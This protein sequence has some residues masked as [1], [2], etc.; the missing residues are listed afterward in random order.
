MGTGTITRAELKDQ[1][2]AVHL[3]GRGSRQFFKLFN[4]FSISG[5]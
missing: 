5:R 1:I 4:G 3:V 2:N